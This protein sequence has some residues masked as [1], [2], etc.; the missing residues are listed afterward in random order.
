MITT[1]TFNNIIECCKYYGSSIAFIFIPQGP[2]IGYFCFTY[3][4]VLVTK[5]R[6]NLSK[7]IS[8]IL[9]FFALTKISLSISGFS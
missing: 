1:I 7:K 3:E 5:D 4:G 2:L 6:F 9:N 8:L